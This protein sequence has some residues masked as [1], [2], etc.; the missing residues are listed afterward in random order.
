MYENY[1]QTNVTFGKDHFRIDLLKHLAGSIIVKEHRLRYQKE[2]FDR[3]AASAKFPDLK[4]GKLT[5]REFA[6]RYA[7]LIETMTESSHSYKCPKIEAS[8]DDYAEQTIKPLNATIFYYFFGANRA[9]RTW[10]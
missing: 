6:S 4:S 5:L 8:Y 10:A 2:Q 3:F 1:Y 9:G 7:L